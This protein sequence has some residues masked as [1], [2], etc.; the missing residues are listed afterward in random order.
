[1]GEVPLY[2]ANTKF[3]R[4]RCGGS[5]LLL[6]N[7][8]ILWALRARNVCTRADFARRVVSVHSALGGMCVTECINKMVLESQLPHKIAN[9]LFR[10]DSE[11]SGDDSAEELTD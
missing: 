11:Q 9:L 10:S 1:M 8:I 3:G 4:A 2:A 5:I 6:R 7:Q